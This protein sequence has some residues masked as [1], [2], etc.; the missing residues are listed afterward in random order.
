MV[1]SERLKQDENDN[2][3]DGEDTAQ[4]EGELLIVS[5]VRLILHIVAASLFILFNSDDY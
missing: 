4:A 2:G 1:P 3:K 5:A